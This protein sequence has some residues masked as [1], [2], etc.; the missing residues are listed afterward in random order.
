MASRLLQADLKVG[1]RGAIACQ[2]SRRTKNPTFGR[3][4]ILVHNAAHQNHWKSLEEMPDEEL[5]RTFRVN[6]YAYVWLVKDALPHL[7][8]GATIIASGS[9]TGIAGSGSLPAYSTSKGA[10]HT[11]T[12]TLSQLLLD[13][14]IRVN[15]V[16]P[17][18]VW[19]P[20]NAADIGRTPEDVATFGKG[21]PIGRPAQ[22]EEVACSA[23]RRPRAR[24]NGG[25]WRD[26]RN[27]T[28]RSGATEG[29][30]ENVLRFP[31][32]PCSTRSLRTLRSLRHG[33]TGEVEIA[34]SYC[35]VSSLAPVTVNARSRIRPSVRA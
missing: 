35:S 27:R 14:G 9:Q 5:D 21:A 19:T 20:L 6:V 31:V 3:L 16:A 17:G 8:P 24:V 10:I 22:P 28:R 12:K 29:V 18:P 2:R 11:L 32:A 4:D 25:G 33:T 1:L 26:R 34:R 7:K 15:C 13:R 30:F 23:A